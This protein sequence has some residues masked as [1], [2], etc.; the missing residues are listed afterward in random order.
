MT[1]SQGPVYELA[2]FTIFPAAVIF[3]AFTDLFTMRISN[4]I[5]LAL[6]A[7]FLVLAPFSGM[8]WQTFGWH[9]AAGVVVLAVTFVLNMLGTFGGGDAKLVSAV[10][11]W[12]GM[13]QLLVYLL[14][15]AMFG[16]TLCLAILAFRKY[17]LPVAWL[18]QTWISRLHQPKGKVP[19]GIALAAGA[20]WIYPQTIWFSGLAG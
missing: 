1:A 3:A 12:V 13:E 16:G 20:L 18:A 17:P 5:S 11:L 8:T 9:L 7:G 15:A 6:I 2:I 19:Y 10:A 14:T 4:R